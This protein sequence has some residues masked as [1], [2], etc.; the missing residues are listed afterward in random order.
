M[1][2]LDNYAE[3]AEN[4]GA[5][6]IAGTLPRMK[7][8]LSKDPIPHKEEIVN[9]LRAGTMNS[10][11]GAYITDFFTG[12]LVLFPDHGRSDGVYRWG[13][14]LAYY[15]DRYNLKLPDAFVAH[16]LKQRKG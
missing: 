6:E 15:V 7:D 13:E 3:Y 8:N 12:E 4:C 5:M 16:V 1:I 11:T 9:Y 2:W 10:A 14:S